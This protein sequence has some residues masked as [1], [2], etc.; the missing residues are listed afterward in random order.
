ML[1]V[2]S[3]L[4]ARL[5]AY[6]VSA[7]RLQDSQTKI[8]PNSERTTLK[9]VGIVSTLKSKA[10]FSGRERWTG[11]DIPQCGQISNSIH[12]SSAVITQTLLAECKTNIWRGGRLFRIARFPSHR[13]V[14][15]K[16]AVPRIPGM[17]VVQPGPCRNSGVAPKLRQFKTPRTIGAFHSWND[18][19]T[20][21]SEVCCGSMN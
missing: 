12:L 7:G 18:L 10:R 21:R 1:S 5:I 14:T 11:P 2:T 9:P 17:S 8:L 6:L 16:P 19:W 15:L 3:Q 20:R 13:E 4:A